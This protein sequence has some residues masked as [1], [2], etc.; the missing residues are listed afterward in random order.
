MQ[1]AHFLKNSEQN[2]A[3]ENLKNHDFAKTSLLFKIAQK[4]KCK[5]FLCLA[6]YF[7][8]VLTVKMR[9]FNFSLF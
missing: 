1:K 2:L 9:E 4:N 5:V 7:E 8:G 6:S 3:I